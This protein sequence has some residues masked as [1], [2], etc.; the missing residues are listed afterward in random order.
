VAELERE[1]LSSAGPELPASVERLRLAVV[2]AAIALLVFVQ[3]GGSLAADT[4]LDLVVDPARFLHRA[5]SLWDPSGNSGQLQDQAYGYLFPMGPFFLLGKLLALPAW[6]LQRCWE[7]ALLIVAFLGVRRLAGLLGVPGFWPPVAAGLA[8]ALAPRMLTEL[9]SISAELLPVAV[10]PWVLIPLVRG[11]TGGS[12]RTAALRSGVALLVAGG[13]NA[14]ATL[15]ILPV[16]ALW[17]LTRPR[18]RR[19][20]SLIRWWLLAVLLSCLWWLIPLITLGKYSPPFLD[21]IESAAVTTSQNSLIAVARGVDHWQDYLGPNI[22]PAGWIYAVAPAAILATAVIAALG[23]AGL[24]L[25]GT[26]HRLFLVGTLLLGFGCLT[27]GHAAPLAGPFAGSARQLLDGSLVAFR[28]IHK[29]DPL[30]RLPLAIG[31]GYL[32]AAAPRGIE[33]CARRLRLPDRLLPGRR[34]AGTLVSLLCLLT[35]AAVALAPALGDHLVQQP[36]TIPIA[37]Y[38]PQ[39]A[40]WLHAHSGDGRTLVVPG[41]GRPVMYWGETIDEPMQAAAESPWATREIVPLGQPGYVRLLDQIE[42][43]LATGV[44]QPDLAPLLARSGIGYLAVR[45]DLTPNADATDIGT[46]LGTL[47][48]SPG[49]SLVDSFG[50]VVR[51]TGADNRVIDRGVANRIPAIQILAVAGAAGPVGMMPVQNVVSANGSAEQLPNLIE[52]GLPA[53]APV[54]FGADGAAVAGPQSVTTDGVR[55][56]EIQFGHPGYLAA[57]LTAGQPFQLARPAHDYLP[58]DAGA[59]SSWQY[60]GIAD[61]RASSSGSDA[62]AFVNRGPDHAPWYAVDGDPHTAWESGSADGAVGQWIELDLAAPV[63]DPVVTIQFAGQPGQNPSALTVRT[64]AG[65]AIQD[66]IPD[67]QPQRLPVPAG[68]TQSIRLTVAAMSGGGRG[69]AVALAGFAVAGVNPQRWLAVPAGGDPDALVFTA[70]IGQRTGCTAAGQGSTCRPELARAGEED[71]GIWRRFGQGEAADYQV[72]GTVTLRPGRALDALLDAGSAIQVRASSTASSD[73]RQRPG[74]MVDGLSETT[75]SAAAGDR[76]PTLILRLRRPALITGLVALTALDAPVTRPTRYRVS[77]GGESWTL[78]PDAAGRLALPTPVS[79]D[80]LTLQ[81]LQST[82]TVSTDSVSGNG[83][84]L[85]AGISELKLTGA[86][87]PAPAGD[88]VI[89]CGQGPVLT[90]DGRQL[91]TS[92][93]ADLATALA[94]GRLPVTPCGSATL[95]VSASRHELSFTSSATTLVQQVVLN[96][97]SG[98]RLSTGSGHAQVLHWGSTSR[99]VRVDAPVATLLVV[100]ENFNDGWQARLAGHRLTAV[101]VDGWQQAFLLPAGAHG[102]LSLTYAPQRPFTIGLWLGLLA[103]VVLIGAAYL[104]RRAGRLGDWQPSAVPAGRLSRPALAT[105]LVVALGLLA[106]WAGVVLAVLLTAAWLRLPAVR[107]RRGWLAAV[108][109]GGVALGGILDAIGPSVSNHPL[110]DSVGCQLL[111]LLALA[112]LGVAVLA[113][114]DEPADPAGRA[115]SAG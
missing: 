66:V 101:Q 104:G 44:P 86:D 107:M 3:S 14:S 18:G 73:P 106:G 48:S 102:V 23:F 79:T 43:M 9:F 94:G 22:W 10:L 52:A 60:A 63:R 93:R 57:T 108:A 49:L 29:F 31:F 105:G 25:R 74:A 51:D 41:A 70:A 12:T 50:P 95:P 65:T 81:I 61:V 82:L 75:W 88:L 37:G 5:L 1:Q 36:R 100:H 112:S 64:D 113:D 33:V 115:D 92:V 17:L 19:R 68:T 47:R 45:A 110:T 96:R 27:F 46:V 109:A 59:L 30:V 83:E 71:D 38:W 32:V 80:S 56:R 21:W 13:V 84:L 97:G 111:V 58:A 26:G 78:R 89:P 34:P 85:P 2:V 69:T 54:L 91:R 28:N 99:T 24:A 6:V 114:S 7:S 90:L 4:K 55:R 62:A 20:A 39:A 11:S 53:S 15:A 103:A 8:Y 77:A 16:P 67:D 72:S 87:L 35:V 40:S 42:S 98:L 76:T